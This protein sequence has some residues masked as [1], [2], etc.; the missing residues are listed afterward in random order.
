MANFSVKGL[1]GVF[2]KV[3]LQGDSSILGAYDNT[4]AYGTALHG[5]PVKLTGDKT[6]GL[7]SAGDEVYG[8]IVKIE[9]DGG[10]SVGKGGIHACRFTG[11][12][13]AAGAA[14]VAGAGNTVA[15]ATAPAGRGTVIGVEDDNGTEYVY[16]DLSR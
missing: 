12:A 10:V 6:V 7:C 3:S 14:I 11:T 2:D 8:V 4:K 15:A 1:H 9:H 5:A 13:P 16:V